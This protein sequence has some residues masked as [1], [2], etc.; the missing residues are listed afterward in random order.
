MEDIFMR[1]LQEKESENQL[2]CDDMIDDYKLWSEHINRG[3]LYH[4]K[5]EVRKS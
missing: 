2:L 1:V 5:P 4:V 3:G